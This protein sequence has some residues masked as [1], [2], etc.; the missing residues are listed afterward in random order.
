MAGLLTGG[1]YDEKRTVR[2]KRT[3]RCVARDS[4]SRHTKR[5]CRELENRATILNIPPLLLKYHTFLIFSLK[6]KYWR[7]WYAGRYW[8]MIIA[9]NTT[10][11][12]LFENNRIQSYTLFD[13]FIQTRI[14]C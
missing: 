14:F 4:I 5:D 10:F 13:H 8:L 3:E 1:F 7:F 2:S 12:Q 9:N 6:K 11:L